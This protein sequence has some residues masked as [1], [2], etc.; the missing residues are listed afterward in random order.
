MKESIDTLL[1]EQAKE[2]LTGEGQ[3]CREESDVWVRRGKKLMELFANRR[4]N[5]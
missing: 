3:L 2:K 4:D 5:H 1:M